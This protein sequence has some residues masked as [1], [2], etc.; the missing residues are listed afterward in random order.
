MP[1]G[2]TACPYRRKVY[3][4]KS[5]CLISKLKIKCINFKANKKRIYGIW[6]FGRFIWYASL[7]LIWTR[8][9]IHCIGFTWTK[10]GLYI[11]WQ[12]QKIHK[13]EVL[14]QTWVQCTYITSKL[15][16]YSS[17]YL[18]LSMSVMKGYRFIP[19]YFLSAIYLWKLRIQ[20]NRIPT[21]TVKTS[22]V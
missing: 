8:I 6:L 16:I 2:D 15:S 5:S 9:R 20:M 19:S 3:H 21:Y 11:P 4:L 18:F 12:K 13:T 22:L 17:F 1:C 14:L 7:H 10:P